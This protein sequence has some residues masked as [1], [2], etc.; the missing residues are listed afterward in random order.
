MR[1][2]TNKKEEEGRLEVFTFI[3]TA[4]NGRRGNSLE[5]FTFICTAQNGT[6][7]N[8]QPVHEFLELLIM[9]YYGQTLREV[10]RL[11][12]PNFSMGLPLGKA[13]ALRGS[14]H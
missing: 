14:E 4:Q 3:C 13:L 7:G 11:C 12:A 2:L 6:N 10:Q 9:A 5:V 8:C 1:I